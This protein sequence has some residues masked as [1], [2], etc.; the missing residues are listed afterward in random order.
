MPCTR[1]DAAACAIPLDTRKDPPRAKV[2]EQQDL[3]RIITVFSKKVVKS[4]CPQH[5]RNSHELVFIVLSTKKRLPVQEKPGKHAAH[6]VAGSRK[7]EGVAVEESYDIFNSSLMS[8][9][10]WLQLAQQ[11]QHGAAYSTSKLAP[12]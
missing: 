8:P 1:V 11:T 9:E 5:Q 10:K 2:Q 6:A 3:S 7:H 4:L 12:T